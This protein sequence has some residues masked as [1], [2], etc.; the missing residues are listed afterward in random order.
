MII[1]HRIHADFLMPSRLDE[2]ARLLRRVIGAGYEVMG[3][4]R[5]WR[6][7]LT[8][9]G[10]TVRRRFVL[11]HDVD[12]DPGTAAAMWRIEHSLGIDGSWFFRLSTRDI[13]LMT[14]IAAAGGEVGYHY[15]ELAT[16]AKERR[17]RTREEALAALP[18]ARNRLRANLEGL[19]AV[20]GLPMRVAASHGDFVNRRLGVPN[21]M[22]L[23]D[24][25]F[26]DQV[27]IDLEGYDDHLLAR[28]PHRSTDAAPPTLWRE[29]DP[30][31]AIDRGEP[32]V[33]VLV[34]PRHWRAAPLT[35]ARDDVQR[36]W[37]G[38]SFARP[39]LRI[40]RRVR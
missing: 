15:E 31:L 19:R 30:M 23:A 3:I 29:E 9:P 12:T 6:S 40:A 39:R 10:T 2:Y 18:E 11:R 24:R 38:A 16:I 32:V 14:A 13:A 36:L 1:W 28:M 21:W 7:A 8:A 26:R 20:T 5:F 33:Y 25:S 22:L 37:Q 17:V 35:N 4:E 27:G 34:H